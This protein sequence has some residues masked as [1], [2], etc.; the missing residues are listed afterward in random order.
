[1]AWK[2]VPTPSDKDLR[3]LRREYRGKVRFLVD[4]NAG[5]E[6]AEFLRSSGFNVKYVDEVG[7]C[8]HSDEDVFAFAWKE[9]RLIVTHDQDFLDNRRFPHWPCP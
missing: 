2:L 1:M 8:G 4:E 7:L 3:E 9:K 5:P 6:V